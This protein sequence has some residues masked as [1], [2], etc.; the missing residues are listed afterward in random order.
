VVP[1]NEGNEV[2]RDGR[3]GFGTFH[4]TVEAG[5]SRPRE[6]LWRKG[7]VVS[8]ESSKGKTAESFGSGPV[9]TKQRRIA[10][11]AKKSPTMV[12]TTLAHHMDLTWLLEA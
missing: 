11:L 4:I 1:P 8:M 12:L 5:E 7:D 2:R 10:E 3:Q 9:C 6:T